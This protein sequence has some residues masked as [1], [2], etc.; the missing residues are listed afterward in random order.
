MIEPELL[1]RVLDRGDPDDDPAPAQVL[2]D[3]AI[4]ADDRPLAAAAL[5]RAFGLDPSNEWVRKARAAVLDELAVT[6]HGMTFRY[7]PTGTFQM[8]SRSGDVDERPVHARQLAAF[9]VAD[10]PMTWPRYCS[11]MDWTPPPQSYPGGEAERRA[12]AHRQQ[13]GLYLENRIR[14]MYCGLRG[15]EDMHPLGDFDQKPMVAVSWQAAAEVAKR[16]SSPSVRYGLPSEA[17]WERAARGGLIGKRYPWG[18]EQP[19]PARCDCDHFGEFVIRPSRSLPPNAYGLYAMCGGVSEWT[20]DAY[21]ALAYHPNCPPVPAGETPAYVLRG[22]SF[23]DCPEAVTV[24]FR[25]SSPSN[26]WSAEGRAFHN[27][28]TFGFRL[29]RWLPRASHARAP[30]AS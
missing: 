22:G 14:A 20:R 21:D 11:L 23:A 13:T 15:L 28:P 6:E 19:D 18:D 16:I 4:E 9:W 3:A 1:D 30:Q 24:S 27:T 10:V 12:T 29:A 8:G 2:A 7:V 17:Q 5:D 26:H 25:A